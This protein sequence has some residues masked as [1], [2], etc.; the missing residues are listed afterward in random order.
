MLANPIGSHVEL[1]VELTQDGNIR[2]GGRG[3][4]LRVTSEVS[5]GTP[6]QI[7]W[8]GAGSP[9]LQFRLQ[10]HAVPLEGDPDPAQ[11]TPFWPFNQPE[12][13]DGLTNLGST[14][15]FTLKNVNFVA[16]YSV[17]VGTLRLDPII[18]VEK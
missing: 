13:E 17:I 11:S 1:D 18:I 2:C 10:F 6:L 8:K 9:P 3:G 7:K 15:T 5:A 14:H 4:N 16:K 12:P